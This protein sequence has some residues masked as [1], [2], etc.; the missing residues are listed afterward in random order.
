MSCC[1]SLRAVPDRP[2]VDSLEI[3]WSVDTTPPALLSL[4]LCLMSEGYS[5]VTLF[6]DVATQSYN[7]LVTSRMVNHD[8]WCWNVP[9]VAQNTQVHLVRMVTVRLDTC[10]VGD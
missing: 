2:V 9:E 5:Y 7:P 1:E 10:R 8:T 4:S 3:K 6:M